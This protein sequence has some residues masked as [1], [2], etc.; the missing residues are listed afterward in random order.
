[1]SEWTPKPGD[2]VAVKGTVRGEI[3]KMSDGSVLNALAGRVWVDLDSGGLLAINSSQLAPWDVAAAARVDA[4]LDAA[5]AL[6]AADRIMGALDSYL[7]ELREHHGTDLESRQQTSRA[8]TRL[9]REIAEL[10]AR[11]AGRH[12]DRETGDAK[13]EAVTFTFTREHDGTLPLRSAVMQAIGRAS[14]CWEKPEGA[15]VFDSAAAEEVGN[16]LLALIGE[17]PLLGL[18]TTRR[19]IEEV[20]ARVHVSE[21]IGEEW[22]LD[23]RTVGAGN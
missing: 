20:A 22:T 11:P 17:E 14:V 2:V 18:A 9:T 6:A 3:T 1:V 12:L 13:G 16:A 21:V 7:F 8:R 23:Y 19:I 5:L 15:G 10:W 4:A